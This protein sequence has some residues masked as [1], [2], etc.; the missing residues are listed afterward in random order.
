MV[1]LSGDAERLTQV[2]GADEEEIE[3]GDGGDLLDDIE[4]RTN[5]SRSFTELAAVARAAGAVA[6]QRKTTTVFSRAP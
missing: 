4:T 2:G 1:P 5:L 3:A 6:P